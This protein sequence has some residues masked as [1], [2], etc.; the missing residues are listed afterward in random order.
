MPLTFCRG[1]YNKTKIQRLPTC[2]EDHARKQQA[3]HEYAPGVIQ[4]MPL[5]LLI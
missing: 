2:Q 5:S 1:Y 4:V 3:E